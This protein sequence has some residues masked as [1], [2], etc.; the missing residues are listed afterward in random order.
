VKKGLGLSMAFAAFLF[1]SA[2]GIALA[3]A[4]P[5]ETV[6]R[7]LETVRGIKKEG[8]ESQGGLT[9]EDSRRNEQLS[10]RANT[11]LDIEGISAYALQDHWKRQSAAN[12]RAFVDLFS[13]LLASVA[14][15]NTSDFL[16]DL[17][18][19]I[20][21]EK[22]IEGKAVVYTSVFHR[23]EGRVD[24]DFELRSH[25]SGWLVEDVLLDGVSLAR[26]L[27]T[28]CLKI[29]RDHSYSELLRRMRSKIENRDSE[30]LKEVTQRD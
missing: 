23:K 9:A 4:A 27:R 11:I 21:K 26:N 19:E 5:S 22:V 8:K 1:W 18:V 17:E 10:E 30:D 7:L 16:G 3:G 25:G 20:R 24:I 6:E 14:Y 13:T 2:W 28:Q 29:I 12:R 15:P